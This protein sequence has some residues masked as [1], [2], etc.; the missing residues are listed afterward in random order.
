MKV[1][2]SILLLVWL[3]P[4]RATVT[5][6]ASTVIYVCN[7]ST[8]TFAVPF[9]FT[10]ASDL[11]VAKIYVSP[12]TVTTLTYGTHYTVSGGN[13]TGSITTTPAGLCYAPFRIRIQRTAATT[14]TTSFSTQGAFSPKVH[15]AALDKLA[16][17]DQ[18]I[19]RDLASAVATEIFDVAALQ[20]ADAA[21]LA[22]TL[23]AV[24]GLNG[25]GHAVTSTS[26]VLAYGSTTPRTLAARMN[27]V[28]NIYD[29][30]ATCT[31]NPV[32]GVGPSDRVAIQAALIAAEGRSLYIPANPGGAC[33]MVEKSLRVP[34]NIKI[35]G[36]GPGSCIAATR[37]G[38]YVRDEAGIGCQD[39]QNYGVLT[40]LCK[41]NVEI[42]GL[43]LYGAKETT[44]IDFEHSPLLIDSQ[45]ST[46]LRVHHNTLEHTHY[47][48]LWGADNVNFMFHNNYIYDAAYVEQSDLMG[49][50]GGGVVQVVGEH[51]T[52]TDNTFWKVGYGISATSEY[53]LITG[54]QFYDYQ[55]FGVFIGDALKVREGL[56]ANNIFE[57]TPLLV[58]VGGRISIPTAI[59]VANASDP[60]HHLASYKN[61]ITI[62][63]NKIR[64][65]VDNV[66]TGFWGI[67]VNGVDALVRGN[68]VE[69]DVKTDLSAG[70]SNNFVGYRWTQADV[71]P[72][73]QSEGNLFHAYTTNTAPNFATALGVV[74]FSWDGSPAL[75]GGGATIWSM[76]NVIRG[77]PATSTAI[78]EGYGGPGQSPL[79]AYHFNDYVETGAVL[80]GSQSL[81]DRDAPIG[82]CYNSA[83]HAVDWQSCG[84]THGNVGFD[85]I[86]YS[87][88]LT[89]TNGVVVL[90]VG[91]YF[92]AAAGVFFRYQENGVPK[93]EFQNGVIYSQ[94]MCMGVGTGWGWGG[95]CWSYGSGA[96]SAADGEG[97]VYSRTD[98]GTIYVRHLGAWSLVTAVP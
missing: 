46:N 77:V 88:T 79:K 39:Q 94:K 87:G 92:N 13:P 64:Y 21:T 3:E 72:F 14:Q 61:T 82:A 40:V 78:S 38:W 27:E 11:V 31:Y 98:T 19:V 59:F 93:T 23:N 81:P 36:D 18:Q 42:T 85:S 67:S 80:I 35:Y 50:T 95:P 16:M 76:N 74:A 68:S 12:E 41:T 52:F 9:R 29:Y 54:N 43:R 15:E 5:T 33:C 20:A 55:G 56:V 66:L 84:I 71:A 51:S 4:A 57:T 22:S 96:P 1:W 24:A 70:A 75:T 69:I 30:G 7:G 32:T 44:D 63:N 47:S 2:F 97:S 48:V 26:S 25:S 65:T 6:T 58:P 37:Y 89:A 49:N 91:V 86:T 45:G 10:T 53:A 34:S 60:W 8:A 62:A 83:V 28:V 90:P 17:V 73:I